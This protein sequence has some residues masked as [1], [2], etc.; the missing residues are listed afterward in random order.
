[1]LQRLTMGTDAYSPLTPQNRFNHALFVLNFLS[2]DLEG[3]SVADR[4]W[5]PRSQD[6][7]AFVQWK[8]PLTGQWKGPDP[9]LIWGRGSA[10]RCDKENAGPG[11]LPERL[12]RTVN[13]PMSKMEPSSPP[14]TH[15]FS[16]PDAAPG[17]DPGDPAA[18]EGDLHPSPA[19][20]QVP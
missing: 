17:K 18:G 1:M 2:L 10:C 14:E 7:H 13:P 15:L 8:D 5:H 6:S 12:I 4:L 20:A 9:V 19:P 11:W 16:L 3:R